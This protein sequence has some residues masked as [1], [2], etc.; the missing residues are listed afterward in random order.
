MQFLAV[1][2]LLCTAGDDGRTAPPEEKDVSRFRFFPAEEPE[3]CRMFMEK[4]F[5]F[6]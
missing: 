4:D 3:K 5:N 2:M 1:K 6:S